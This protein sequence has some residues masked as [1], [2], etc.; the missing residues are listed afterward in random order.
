[1]CFHSYPKKNS[2]PNTYLIV[3]ILAS[4]YRFSITKILFD[5][6]ALKS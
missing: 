4:N 3:V 6:L 1:M 5:K 2:G